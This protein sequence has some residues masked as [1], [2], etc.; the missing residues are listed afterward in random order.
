MQADNIQSLELTALLLLTLKCL[1]QRDLRLKNGRFILLG[2][3]QR[4]M[5]ACHSTSME[6]RHRQLGGRYPGLESVPQQ[7]L[8]GLLSTNA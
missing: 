8:I 4:I 6:P 2:R 5:L 3:V 1:G 7:L